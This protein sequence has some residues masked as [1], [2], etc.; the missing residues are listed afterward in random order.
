MSVNI[1]L[2]SNWTELFYSMNYMFYKFCFYLSRYAHNLIG[3]GAFVIND[4]DELLVVR[5]RFYKHPHWKL[6]GGYVEPG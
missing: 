4:S 2:V 6:P 3:V 1:I 5:E